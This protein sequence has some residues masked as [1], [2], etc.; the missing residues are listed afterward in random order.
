MI[1]FI[2]FKIFLSKVVCP[3]QVKDGVQ[4]T[5]RSFTDRTLVNLNDSTLQEVA[6]QFGIELDREDL[7]NA[8]LPND[9]VKMECVAWMKQ[10]FLCTGDHVPNRDGEIHLDSCKKIEIYR[11]YLRDRLTY[12][13]GKDK[14]VD[15]SYE[16]YLDECR[17]LDP[18]NTAMPVV[19]ARTFR[20]L[21]KHCFSHVKVCFFLLFEDLF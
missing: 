16:E 12:L 7:A 8:R 3:R 11:E 13:A 21:W 4:S 18:K 1:L 2:Y 20:K 14:V 9:P 5:Q 17:K 10:Y 15:K 19:S 6:S